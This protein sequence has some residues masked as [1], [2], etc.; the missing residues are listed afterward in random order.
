MMTRTR[1]QP[2][3]ILDIEGLRVEVTRKKVHNLN[4]RVRRDGTVAVSVGPRVP[5]DRVVAFVSSRRNWIEQAQRRAKRKEQKRT[6]TCSEGSELDLWGKRLTCHIEPLENGGSRPS[7]TFEVTGTML[8]AHCSGF[9]LGDDT[10]AG[11][12]REKALLSWLAATLRETATPMLRECEKLVGRSSSKLRFRRM[13]SRWG[14][15]NV[16]AAAITLNTELVHYPPEC[17]R[18][19]IIHELCHLYEPNHGPHFHELMDRF[20]PSWREIRAQLNRR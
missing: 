4:L 15:C 12:R 3:E 11:D 8:V 2:T 16:K 17:L 1:M 10:Q 6:I 18:Y 20:C 14:S 5:T 19:V 13:V 9:F 7:C